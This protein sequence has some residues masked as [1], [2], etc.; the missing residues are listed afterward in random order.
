MKRVHVARSLDS[1]KY[2]EVSETDR[3][4]YPR[5]PYRRSPDLRINYVPMLVEFCTSWKLARTHTHTH[6]HTPS[7]T[8]TYIG[9]SA[10]EIQL[11]D[12]GS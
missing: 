11:Q 4:A 1:A 8:C 7:I 2:V 3:S 10:L 6:T 12:P 5:A 9:R